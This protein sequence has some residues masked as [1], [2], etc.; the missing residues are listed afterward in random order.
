[1][2]KTP[3]LINVPIDL[4]SRRRERMINRV[5]HGNKVNTVRGWVCVQSNGKATQIGEA[6]RMKSRPSRYENTN[7]VKKVRE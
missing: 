6:S 1:M 4:E 5:F 2:Q 7:Q 3:W